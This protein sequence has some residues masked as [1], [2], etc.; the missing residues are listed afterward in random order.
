MTDKG[1]SEYPEHEKLRAVV[2]KSQTIGDFL[3]WL[4]DEKRWFLAAAG[5][6]PALEEP[7]D[8]RPDI[9]DAFSSI[10]EQVRSEIVRVHYT[11]PDLLAEFFGIDQGKLEAEK[12]AMLAAMRGD[13]G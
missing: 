3:E 1:R 2:G 12:L 13:E 10:V 5:V 11:I 7:E 8:R 4:E 6:P 9:V